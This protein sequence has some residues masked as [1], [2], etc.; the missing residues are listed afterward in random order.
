MKIGFKLTLMMFVLSILITGSVAVFLLFQAGNNITSLSHDK[1]IATASGYAA[2]VEAFL[3]ANWYMLETIAEMVENHEFIPDYNRRPFINSVFE[4]SLAIKEGLVGIWGFWDPDVLEGDDSIYVGSPGTNTEG[5][6]APYWYRGAGGITRGFLDSASISGEYYL[7]ARRNGRTTLMNPVKRYIG[8]REYLIATIAR[9]IFSPEGRIQGVIGIDIDLESLHLNAQA[10]IPFG[11]GLTAVFANNGIIA[12][13]FDPLR[14]GTLMQETERDMAGPHLDGFINAIMKGEL[15]YY[16]HFIQAA[17]AE[18]NVVAIPI[19]VGT[20]ES[21]WSYAIGVPVK[22]V[23]SALYYMQGITIVISL[24][25][26]CIVIPLA[27]YLSRSISKPIVKI[28]GALEDIAEGEG[29]LTKVIEIN[30]KD[31]IGIMAAYF[32]QT[33]EKIRNMVMEI[34][35][36]TGILSEIG[37][38]LA[39]NMNETAAAI[40]EITANVKN[41]RGRIV[42]QSASVTETN[43]TMEQISSTID[44]LNGHVEDQ[45]SNISQACSAVEEMAANIHSVNQT[46]IGNS[47]SVR[48]LMEAS[49]VGRLG[50]SDVAADIQEIARDSEGLLE[51]NSVMKNIAGQTNLLSMNAAIEA[52]HAG[53]AGKGFAVVADEIRKLAESSGE[54]S[55][56]ISML[57]KKIKASIDKITG[58]TENVLGKFESIDFCVKTVAEQEEIIRNAMEEQDTGSRQLLNGINSVNEFSKNVKRGSEEMLL[59][60]REVMREGKNLEQMTQEIN[61]GISE[62][63]V[64]SDQINAAVTKVNELSSKTRDNI[65]LLAKEVS[66]FKV[67]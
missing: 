9:P 51:I 64:S 50:L 4:N 8:G 60:S 10:N 15:F 1:A 61:S 62:M 30:S 16:T 65:D 22:T 2:E 28:A 45:S 67:D 18:F 52:A 36:D 5:I 56:T 14:L 33:I 12:S 58:S 42:S 7:E 63:A 26:I 59:G 38:E 47:A 13:H 46:L 48:E 35:S 55:K 34:K 27:I 40:N 23:M 21:P 57:L 11:N 37:D 25:I 19:Y 17:G 44:T 3:S 54:Q 49:E 6:F 39:G 29:D 66:R 31:E 43:A 32:N 24:V 53:E 41:I 20:S